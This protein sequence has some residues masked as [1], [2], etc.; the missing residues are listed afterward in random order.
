MRIAI[1]SDTH[2]PRFWK[3]CP[4]AVADNLRNGVDLILH[5]GDICT[6]GVLDELKAFAPVR[7]VLGNNDTEAVA[8]SGVPEVDEFAIDGVNFAMI[9]DSGAATGRMARMRKRFPVADCVIFGHSHIPMNEVNDD[10]TL[11]LFNPGSPTDKRRQPHRTM[12]FI[13][14]TAGQLTKAEIARLA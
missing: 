10:K 11:R 7:A 4:D 6:P 12:G 3:K 5:A 14:V 9:H 2:A 1:L 13:T 8:R